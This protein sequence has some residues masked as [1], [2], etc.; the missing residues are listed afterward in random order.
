M[1]INVKG[2]FLMC[3]EMVFVMIE[4]CEGYIINIVLQVVLNG[5]VKVGVY[6]VL[7]FVMV[8]FGKVLQEEVCEYGIYVYLLNFVLIQLLC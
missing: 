4:N 2:I 7:K 8:G 1:N 6:C 3:K 5:Y